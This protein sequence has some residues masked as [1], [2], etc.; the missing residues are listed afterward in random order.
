MP[1]WY[2]IAFSISCLPSW[3]RA[4]V[5]YSLTPIITMRCCNTVPLQSVPAGSSAIAVAP[6]CET[7]EAKAVTA[8]WT[9]DHSEIA[10]TALVLQVL[11]VDSGA[12][13]PYTLLEQPRLKQYHRFVITLERTKS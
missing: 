8:G 10:V 1:S 4:A 7:G 9:L 6:V 12:P 2:R 13:T 5:E 3:V 11:C